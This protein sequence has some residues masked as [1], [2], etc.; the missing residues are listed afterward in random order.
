VNKFRKTKLDNLLTVDRDLI[1]LL[2]SNIILASDELEYKKHYCT[3]ACCIV[4]LQS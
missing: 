4:V 2:T 3:A 1:T